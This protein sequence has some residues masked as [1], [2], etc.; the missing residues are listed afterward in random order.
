M[1]REFKSTDEGMT[2]RAEN[3]DRVGTIQKIEGNKA[4]VKPKSGLSQRIR[5][6]LGWGDDESDVYELPHSRV[7]RIAGDE[8]HLKD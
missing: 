3:G 8:V 2:V 1:V 7:H 4:H 6:R 5:T